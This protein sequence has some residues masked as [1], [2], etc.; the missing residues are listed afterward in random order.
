M[1]DLLDGKEDISRILNLRGITLEELRCRSKQEYLQETRQLIVKLL[2]DRYGMDWPE[3]ALATGRSESAVKRM[4]K[5]ARLLK[6][7]ARC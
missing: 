5:K 7:L 6:S 2:R 3:I 4:Y 1:P